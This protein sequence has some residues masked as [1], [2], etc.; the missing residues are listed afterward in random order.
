M[1]VAC[2]YVRDDANSQKGCVYLTNGRM[3][4]P[5]YD[6]SHSDFDKHVLFVGGLEETCQGR[7][8]G[9]AQAED[10]QSDQEAKSQGRKRKEII[11]IA[12][13][14]QALG[15]GPAAHNGL[16]I[17]VWILR[18]TILASLRNKEVAVDKCVSCHQRRFMVLRAF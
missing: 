5:A 13:L 6:F 16:F 10:A 17:C 1:Y 3:R 8:G 15:W 2:T 7:E 12:C 11:K 18:C 4:I 9:S 14:H